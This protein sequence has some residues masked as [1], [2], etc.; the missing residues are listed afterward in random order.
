VKVRAEYMWLIIR[1]GGTLHALC[2]TVEL[3]LFCSYRNFYIS[4]HLVHL[5]KICLLNF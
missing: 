1:T 2:L 5:L 3:S 4:Y